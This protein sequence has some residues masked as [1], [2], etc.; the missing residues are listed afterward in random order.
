MLIA[1][2]PTRVPVNSELRKRQ[3]LGLLLLAGFVLLLG[4]CRTPLRDIFP[5]GWWRPW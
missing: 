5:P 3:I 1:G 2:R 4:I